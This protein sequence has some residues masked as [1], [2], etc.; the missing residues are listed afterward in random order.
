MD[1]T[2]RWTSRKFWL[3]IVYLVGCL[4]LLDKGISSGIDLASLGIAFG[5][6]STG[7]AAVIW[8]N[9]KAKQNGQD[10]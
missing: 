4:Y 10:G 5:G 2:T 9:V 3:G 6:M 7:V 8:G 1:L